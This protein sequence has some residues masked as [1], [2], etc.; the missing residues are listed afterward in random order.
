MDQNT[1]TLVHQSIS[2]FLTT[3]PRG[4]EMPSSHNSNDEVNRVKLR[5]TAVFVAH[6]LSTIAHCDQIIVMKEG[7]VVETGTHDELLEIP[8][9][10]YASMWISQ[11]GLD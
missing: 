9:G 11:Q 3:P 2:N 10:L 5:H 6:R 1:E 7:R 4:S 8:D